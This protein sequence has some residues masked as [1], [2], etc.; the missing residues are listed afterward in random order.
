MI[1]LC[2]FGSWCDSN[3]QKTKSV[4]L[5]LLASQINQVR[6]KKKKKI[7]LFSPGL[8]GPSR[9]RLAFRK[10]R[11]RWKMAI[12]IKTC[13]TV[14]SVYQKVGNSLSF[15]L[16]LLST[17]SESLYHNIF[18]WVIIMSVVLVS[19]LFWIYASTS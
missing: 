18:F 16:I 2:F 19:K 3:F 5:N 13:M 9:V 1:P 10:E 4:Q 8:I 7:K 17:S 12:S 6:I 11:L 14:W 15:P